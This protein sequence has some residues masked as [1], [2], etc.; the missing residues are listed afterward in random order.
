[1]SGHYPNLYHGPDD[2]GGHSKYRTRGVA[3]RLAE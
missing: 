2:A 3:A 1:M